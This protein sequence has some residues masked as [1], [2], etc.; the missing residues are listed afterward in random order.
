MTRMSPACGN[1]AGG[2]TTSI[3]SP[4]LRSNM[5]CDHLTASQPPGGAGA[6]KVCVLFN[7]RAGSADRIE[8]LRAA[9]AADPRVTLRE[10]GPDD[11][12][13]RAAGEAGT[14][15]DVV[16]V[17][18]GDGTVHTAINGLVTARARAALAVIPLGTGNDFCRTMAIPLDPV[19]AVAL[20]RTGQPRAVDVAKL[21]GD[22]TGFM[23]NAATGGFSG[24]VAA[25]VTPD[26]KAFWGPLAYLRG[27]V[28][29]VTNPP[30]YRLT[31]RFDDGAPES[32]DA[33]NV[34]VANARTAGGG[35]PV[36]PTA[37]PEDGLL[38]VVVVR[39]AGALE[40]SVVAA[41]LMHGDYLGDENVV[42][43]L[44]RKVEI[45]SHPALPVSI[46]G[47][48]D[49]GAR[50]TFEVVPGAL[51]VLAGPEYRARA[52][53]ERPLEEHEVPSVPK[54]G[55][56]PRFFGLL[57]GALLLAKRTPGAALAGF[58]AA[59]MILVF[60]WVARGVVGERWRDWDE[61]VGTAARAGADW[62]G[63]A[64]A[65]TALGDAGPFAALVVVTVAV[66]VA[67]R[68]YVDAAALLAVVGG[69]LILEGVLKPLFA[70]ARPALPVPRHAAQGFSF[71]SGHAL[72][73]VGFFGYLGG[74]AV[75]SAWRAWGRWGVA[76][77]CAVL[78]GAVCWS[79]V[80]L[81]VHHPTDVIAGA[82]A[83]G[84][85]VATCLLGRHYAMDRMNGRG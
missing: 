5:K 69:V 46:D 23:V 73:A 84:A 60:A 76:I 39:S 51:R 70:V 44:A 38:D 24:R 50:F 54:K 64:V 82:L 57:G 32:F 63:V 9:L 72:R 16:A 65:V 53:V 30:Q 45:E 18:G 4:V 81:G 15:Y 19:A 67:R 48:L 42:H 37:N 11:D 66:L 29:T 6:T 58:A 28:G 14:T 2:S 43:R 77:G 1:G 83:A 71:P 85:W 36:A 68:R 61:R 13:G 3:D 78:A 17:A 12:L 21:G 27:A 10:L 34:V 52:E 62:S 7:P 41:R 79:R 56:G 55:I 25:D 8:E 80:Y 26:L 47:E 74:M 35:T 20:L 49:E 40:L 75:A 22:R 33:L 59:L 31:V